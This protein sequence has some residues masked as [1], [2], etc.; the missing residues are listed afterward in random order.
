MGDERNK[1]KSKNTV[2]AVSRI[3]HGKFKNKATECEMTVVD[4]MDELAIAIEKV[5]VKKQ[6]TSKLSF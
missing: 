6:I 3:A 2:L 4:F 1:P 5:K